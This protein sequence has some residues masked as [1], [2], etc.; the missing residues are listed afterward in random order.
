MQI[1]A[2]L[3]ISFYVF[4]LALYFGT[5]YYAV[6]FIQA[7]WRHPFHPIAVHSRTLW[8]AYCTTAAPSTQPSAPAT[9]V[10]TTTDS[11][12]SLANI[13]RVCW[14]QLFQANRKHISRKMAMRVRKKLMSTLKKVN[15]NTWYVVYARLRG[16]VSGDVYY[17]SERW[18]GG[19]RAATDYQRLDPGAQKG[20]RGFGFVQ[21]ELGGI[22]WRVWISGRRRQLLAV[23]TTTTTSTTTTT[24]L[25]LLLAGIWQTLSSHADG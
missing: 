19:R 23:T 11:H 16:W 4:E 7:T 10:T 12:G 14:Q 1:A 13:R 5:K 22:S 6:F 17:C 21:Q 24:L 8:T 3:T 9:H 18:P 25:P 15:S 20:H 2:Y